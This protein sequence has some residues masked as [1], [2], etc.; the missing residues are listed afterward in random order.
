MEFVFSEQDEELLARW[1]TE[2]EA[3]EARLAR[4]ELAILTMASGERDAREIER[5]LSGGE[6]N[7]GS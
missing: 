6:K 1:R 2:D 7:Q 4:I 5:I 3:R